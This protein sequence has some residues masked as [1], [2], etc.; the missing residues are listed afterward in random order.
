MKR[1]LRHIAF[2]LITLL[3][4]ACIAGIYKTI[5]VP[6]GTKIY[7]LKNGLKVYM[8]FNKESRIQTYIAV[9]GDGKNVP[10]NQKLCQMRTL[11]NNAARARPFI[12]SSLVCIIQHREFLPEGLQS[13]HI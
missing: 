7:T 13:I 2:T 11:E 9:R 5:A 8:S 4:V 3:A 10:S 1:F 12:E 6:L